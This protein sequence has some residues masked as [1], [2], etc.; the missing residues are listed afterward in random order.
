M[1]EEERRKGWQRAVRTGRKRAAKHKTPEKRYK[2]L[3]KAMRN[4]DEKYGD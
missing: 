3:D 4:A 1:T 2:V